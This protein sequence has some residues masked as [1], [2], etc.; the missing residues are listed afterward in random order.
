MT[1]PLQSLVNPIDVLCCSWLL[2]TCPLWSLANP[3]GFQCLPMQPITESFS[4]SRGSQ[5]Y[6]WCFWLPKQCI[7]CSLVNRTGVLCIHL[8]SMTMSFQIP[9][10]PYVFPCLPWQCLLQSI[11]NPTSVL[12]GPSLTK[13]VYFA[14]WILLSAVIYSLYV[15]MLLL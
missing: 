7:L 5:Q 8:L 6:P 12:C 10:V 11:V 13:P 3:T 9:P 14:D 4:V 15:E 2:M 1:C